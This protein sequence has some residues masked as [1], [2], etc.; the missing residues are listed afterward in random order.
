MGKKAISLQ[1]SALARYRVPF[2]AGFS[3]PFHIN[4]QPQRKSSDLSKNSR[5]RCPEGH[6]LRSPWRECG[7]VYCKEQPGWSSLMLYSSLNSVWASWTWEISK[8]FKDIRNIFVCNRAFISV[9]EEKSPSKKI[10][11]KAHIMCT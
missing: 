4:S 1:H 2:K 11:L 5:P 3:Q 6:Q 10:A 8:S 7:L 9:T